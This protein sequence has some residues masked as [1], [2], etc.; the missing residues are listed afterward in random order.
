MKVLI[1]HVY[2]QNCRIGTPS[3]YTSKK[4]K[5]KTSLKQ[6]L[7]NISASKQFSQQRNCTNPTR[8]G[9]ESYSSRSRSRDH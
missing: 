3:P 7:P 9:I 4:L 8:S 6:L 5:A 1:Y 2:A